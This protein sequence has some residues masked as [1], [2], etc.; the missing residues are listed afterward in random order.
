MSDA[1]NP[2]PLPAAGSTPV[3]ET[4]PLPP[5]AVQYRCQVVAEILQDF[6][7]GID[8]ERLTA[9]MDWALRGTQPAALDAGLDHLLGVFA[10]P[11]HA[12]KEEGAWNGCPSAQAE[13]N[14]AMANAIAALIESADVGATH[15][16][17]TDVTAERMR[18]ISEEGWTPDH[19]DS[20]DLGELGLAAALY[21]LPYEAEVAGEKLLE[22]DDFIRLDIVL[23]NACNWNLKPDGDRRR[24]MVKAG[25]LI[26]AEIERLD[27]RA[28]AR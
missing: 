15:T 8:G 20:H 13:T 7:D 24:R 21:A 4:G 22:Q 2:A 3:T 25:A 17:V 1:Q 5:L 28:A 23:T 18:Q 6:S 26:L 9:A 11:W 12:A 16:A 10:A 14:L 19:D 27:R